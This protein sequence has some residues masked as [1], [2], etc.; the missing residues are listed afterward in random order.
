MELFDMLAQLKMQGVLAAKKACVLAYWASRA[1][2]SGATANLAYP[3]G[4]SS[5]GNYSKHFDRVVGI[6][7]EME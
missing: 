7:E 6:K 2:A 1:G 5:T 3:P 4:S